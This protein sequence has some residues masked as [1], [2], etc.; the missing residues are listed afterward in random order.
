MHGRLDCPEVCAYAIDVCMELILEPQVTSL[1]EIS[2]FKSTLVRTI[3][4]LRE[5]ERKVCADS[6]G[7]TALHSA[8][9]IN[10]VKGLLLPG[11]YT[12][13]CGICPKHTGLHVARSTSEIAIS[14]QRANRIC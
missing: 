6:R 7:S 3:T 2:Y 10:C 8:S 4:D 11:Y 14:C 5:A 9:H 12:L 13:W 1:P